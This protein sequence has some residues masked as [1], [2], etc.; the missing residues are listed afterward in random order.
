M[1]LGIL[2]KLK[3]IAGGRCL[4]AA[5]SPIA[6]VMTRAAAASTAAAFPDLMD[7]LLN[8]TQ[9]LLLRMEHKPLM[10]TLP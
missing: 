7:T 8:T 6:G 3:E 10:L 1:K 5:A 9:R 2:S 4:P